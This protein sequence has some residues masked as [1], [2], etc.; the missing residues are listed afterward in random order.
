MHQVRLKA[1]GVALAGCV[2]LLQAS[3]T[4]RHRLATSASHST[5][6]GQYSVDLVPHMELRIENAY[7]RDSMP[8]RGTAGYLGTATARFEVRGRSGLL[9]LSVQSALTRPPR[10]QPPVQELILPSQRRYR[11]YRFFYAIVFNQR[12]NLHGSVLL[13][14]RSQDEIDRLS[15]RLRMEPDAVCGG[16][17]AHCTVFPEMCTVSIDI[18][19]LVNGVARTVLSGSPLSSVAP[20]AKHVALLRLSG[21]HLEPFKIDSADPG[22]LR[23]PLLPGDQVKW[24]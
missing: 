13:G 3:C 11:L 21:G 14:A 8:K 5:Q 7:Y 4:A 23:T 17:S 18:Q 22:A 16:A 20:G 2:L 12:G 9:L 1:P 6:P 15:E 19:I 24:E 10:D